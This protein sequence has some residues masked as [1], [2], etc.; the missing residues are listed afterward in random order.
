[1]A[2]ASCSARTAAPTTRPEGQ[3]AD[4]PAHLQQDRHAV[5][6]PRRLLHLHVVRELARTIRRWLGNAPTTRS[7]TSSRITCRT[8]PCS[9]PSGCWPSTK[10]SYLIATGALPFG[11]SV[12]LAK[13]LSGRPARRPRSPARRRCSRCCWGCR[14]STVRT[15]RRP[16]LA[17]QFL[18]YFY[19]FQAIAMPHLLR[20]QKPEER[21]HQHH[22]VRL[23]SR[24]PPFAR[25]DHEAGGRR[26]AAD[27]R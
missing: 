18:M 14:S 13:R 19:S 8:W 10:W 3:G 4:A 6:L 23:A 9:W 7:A 24:P 2:L 12:P 5:R 22:R 1:M 21:P 20:G 25:S 11:A 27:V 16:R 26:E 17:F 15:T